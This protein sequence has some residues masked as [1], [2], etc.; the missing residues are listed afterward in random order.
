MD[1]EFEGGWMQ[2]VMDGCR[3]C[4]WMDAEF[5]G[6]WMQSDGGWMQGVMVDGCRV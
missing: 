6:G 1:A 5:E 3:V 2:G 4:W